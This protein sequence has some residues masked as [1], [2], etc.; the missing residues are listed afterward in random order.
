[1]IDVDIE[2]I[3]EDDEK[4]LYRISWCFFGEHKE[5]WITEYKDTDERPP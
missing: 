3:H 2:I 4:V 1:M 5:K